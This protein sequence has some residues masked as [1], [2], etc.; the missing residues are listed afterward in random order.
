[1][2]SVV[3]GQDVGVE[4][5]A[6]VVRAIGSGVAL[7][8][9][10]GGNASSS[11]HSWFVVTRIVFHSD[12][13][14]W[15]ING[16][17]KLSW[18]IEIWLGFR[19]CQFGVPVGSGDDNV[20]VLAVSTFIGSR[21]ICNGVAPESTFEVGNA[22]R[23][24]AVVGG[25]VLGIPLHEDVDAIATVGRVAVLLTFDGVE[26]FEGVETHV[27]ISLNRPLE[28]AEGLLV[29]LRFHGALSDA[30]PMVRCLH[31]ESDA[32]RGAYGILRISNERLGRVWGRGWTVTIGLERTAA[33]W[34]ITLD[35]A[36]Y[37]EVGRNSSVG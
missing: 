24:F 25:V 10:S 7:I 22:N 33:S 2:G 16:T 37:R 34:N 23:V 31:N 5:V 21:G 1:M 18:A 11:T 17:T 6:G 8:V 3:L 19:R 20:E 4:E 14:G 27:T 28:V 29:T 26:R 30:L 9:G 32:M 12:I 15:S 36:S 13:A 35:T